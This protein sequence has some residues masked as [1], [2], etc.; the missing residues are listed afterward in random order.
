LEG[1]LWDQDYAPGYRLYATDRK[2]SSQ[3]VTFTAKYIGRL[4]DPA[5]VTSVVALNRTDVQLE[6][7][8]TGTASVELTRD[9]TAIAMITDPTVHTFVDKNVPA[10]THH[11]QARTKNNLGYQQFPTPEVSVTL[12]PPP[13]IQ[14]IQFDFERGSKGVQVHWVPGTSELNRYQIFRAEDRYFTKAVT[15]IHTVEPSDTSPTYIDYTVKK[16]IDYWYRVRAINDWSDGAFYG[17][18]SEFAHLSKGTLT[19]S[20]N[21]ADNKITVTSTSTRVMIDMDGTQRN[22]TRSKVKRIKLDAA[23]GFDLVQNQSDIASTIVGGSEDD[24][25][26]G[27]AGADFIDGGAGIDIL[28]GR[29]GSD[30]LQGGEG[31]DLI[32]AKD[33]TV[34]LIFGG[35]GI[36]AA[37]FDR[38]KKYKD[39]MAEVESLMS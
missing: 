27:G 15:L 37:V 4:P 5:G 3:F 11:Y 13:A 35:A 17:A 19:V 14:P 28:T 32:R 26:V 36:D 25:L 10:G 18:G 12:P 9:G 34:D 2:A 39:R 30:T 31:D 7:R 24:T 23:G 8:N 21:A 29:G 20:G 16:G 1:R 38:V 22:F 33:H 6:I